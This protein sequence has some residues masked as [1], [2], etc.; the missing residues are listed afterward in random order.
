MRTRKVDK[1]TLWYCQDNDRVAM[2][3]LT[4]DGEVVKIWLTCRI[5]DRLVP[6]LAQCNSRSD[7]PCETS[8]TE[9]EPAANR[10]VLESDASPEVLVTAIH[11]AQSEQSTTLG[12]DDQSRSE[13]YSLSLADRDMQKWRQALRDCFRRG[14]WSEAAWDFEYGFGGEVMS[15]SSFTIH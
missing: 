9:A 11:I 1:V 15:P 13:R 2:N 8:D 14:G 5:L 10:K 7:V 6:H 4:E 3:T 12:F